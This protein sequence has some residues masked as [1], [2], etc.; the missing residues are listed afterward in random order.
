MPLGIEKRR[1]PQE[2]T[3]TS[4]IVKNKYITHIKNKN[5]TLPQYV[6]R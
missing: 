2:N 4:C 5:E 3:E 6:E 1:E